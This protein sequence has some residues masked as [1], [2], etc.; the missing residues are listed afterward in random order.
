MDRSPLCDL[1]RLRTGEGVCLTCS[2]HTCGGNR[3]IHLSQTRLDIRTVGPRGSWLP[4]L[5]ILSSQFCFGIAWCNSYHILYS[6][7]ELH[8]PVTL[9]A[10]PFRFTHLNYRFCILH[11]QV[12]FHFFDSCCWPYHFIVY[13]HHSM[14]NGAL[15]PVYCSHSSFH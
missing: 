11:C 6:L 13:R 5:P 10:C 4:S 7:Q 3:D 8:A 12:C 1:A 2:S 15:F 14:P 9:F